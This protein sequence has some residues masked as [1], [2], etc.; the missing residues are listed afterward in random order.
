MT[1]I[2]GPGGPTTTNRIDDGALAALLD[3]SPEAR[4]VVLEELTARL[5]RA[6]LD[7]A[8]RWS[9]DVGDE[10]LD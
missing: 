1:V 8:Q 7:R 10:L 3:H 2:E 5:R 4:Q 9:Q 6:D